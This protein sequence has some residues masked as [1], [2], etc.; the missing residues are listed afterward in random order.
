MSSAS[1]ARR[2]RIGLITLTI[3]A[4]MLLGGQTVL[5]PALDGLVF[6]VY[7]LI[8]FF[9]TVASIFIAI[10]DV[11]ALRRHSKEIQQEIIEDTFGDL[12]D[13]PLAEPNDKEK[14]G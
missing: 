5:A 7:W 13:H 6:L 8:C 10:L 11:R 12:P 9:F 14:G 1:D 2:R 3:A 4:L